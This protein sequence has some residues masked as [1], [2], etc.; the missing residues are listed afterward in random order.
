VKGFVALNCRQ[1]ILLRERMLTR[2]RKQSGE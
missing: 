2:R 1:R